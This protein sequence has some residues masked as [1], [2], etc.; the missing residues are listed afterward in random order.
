[1]CGIIAIINHNGVGIDDKY[2]AHKMLEAIQHR[3]KDQAFIDRHSRC[4]VGYRRLAITEI[5]AQLDSAVPSDFPQWSVYLNGEIYNYKQLANQ[6]GI[7]KASETDVLK[8]GFAAH[9]PEFVRK[10]N[11]M[12]MIVAEFDG[13]VYFFRDRY[14]IKPGYLSAFDGGILFASEIK[15][16]LAHPSVAVKENHRAVDQWLTFNNVFTSDT[17]FDGIMEFPAATWA[18][19]RPGSTAVAMHR[20]WKWEYKTNPIDYRDAV[21]LTRELVIQAIQ[22][23][24]PDEVAFGCCLSGGIDSNIILSQLNPCPSFTVGFSGVQDERALAEKQCDLNYHVVYSNV[25]FMRESITALEDLKVGASW[26]NYGLCLLASKFCKVLFDG[27]GA[28]ELFGGYPWRYDMQTPYYSIVNRTAAQDKEMEAL[29][30]MIYPID[31]L[32]NRMVF[33]AEHFMKGVLHVGDRMSM[34]HTIEMRVPFLDNDLVDFVLTLPLEFLQGKR[35]LK[36]AFYGIISEEVLNGKK[37][38]FS[39]PDWFH[40]AGEN[41]AARWANAALKEWRRIF[42]N[43]GEPGQ[44]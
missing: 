3:G 13:S 16:L 14:G 41:Q 36:D 4:V 7:E 34:A 12:F 26:S 39:S 44:I 5:G 40:N 43:S 27:T 11:G 24:T 31:T 33:D 30:A 35:L 8:A 18:V 6:L 15:A 42:I 38:G 1:M 29:F 37:R 23:Q 32:E 9:G 2:N 20:Y 28:D 22:R 21:E 17:F 25:Q 10:L 19:I